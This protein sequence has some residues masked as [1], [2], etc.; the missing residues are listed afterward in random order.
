MVELGEAE[1]PTEAVVESEDDPAPQSTNGHTQ[2]DLLKL[3]QAEYNLD[4]QAVGAALKAAGFTRFDTEKL[5]EM[6]SALNGNSSEE[7]P[8]EESEQEPVI[9]ET[10]EIPM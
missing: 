4:G 9:E 7:E 3:A 6:V 1:H 2:A 5:D 10:V 8:I